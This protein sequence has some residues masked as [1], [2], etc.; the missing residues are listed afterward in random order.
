[1]AEGA[2]GGLRRVEALLENDMGDRIARGGDYLSDPDGGGIL[3]DSGI[4]CASWVEDYLPG[5]LEVVRAR[6]RWDHGVDCFVDAEIASAGGDGAPTARLVTA[7]DEGGPRTARLVGT[8]GEIVV[9]DMHRP[10]RARLERAGAAPVELDLPY[11]VDDFHDEIEHFV[12][13][14]LAGRAESDVMPLAASLRCAELLDAVRREMLAGRRS[15]Q[16]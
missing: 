15:P 12:D 9:D 5:P 4:Y 2:I 11:P 16:R 3:L 14:L 7:A 13:L 6:A 8:T 10:Q 1:M